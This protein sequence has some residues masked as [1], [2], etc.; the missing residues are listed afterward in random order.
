MPD[1]LIKVVV[2]KALSEQEILPHNRWH[3]DIPPVASVRPG[4]DFITECLDWT[5]G[6]I[7]N[8]DGANDVRDVNLKRCHHLFGPIEAK[9]AK[10]GDL[11]VVDILDI[12]PLPE[13]RWGLYGDLRQD[14]RRGRGQPRSRAQTQAALDDRSLSP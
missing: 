5:G 4:T 13:P 6:Q 9:G 2:L 1:T 10:P 7:V 8:D 11:L 14:H 3:P 12:G